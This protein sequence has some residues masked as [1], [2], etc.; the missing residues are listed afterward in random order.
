MK[1]VI[2]ISLREH[3]KALK[4]SSMAS[5]IETH[6]RQAK[7]SGIGYDEFLLDLA[8]TE[9]QVR[10]ENRLT[11][12]IRDAKFPLLKPVETFDLNAVP[13]LDMRLFRD[14]CGCNY[15]KEHRNVIFL[16]GSGTGKTH[17]ATALG[18]EA[19][20]AN[21]RTRFISGYGLVNELLE[22][23]ETRDLTRIMHRYSR[24]DLL[25]LDELGYIPFS[26]EGSELL[27]QVLAERYERGSVMITTNLGFADW[28]QV[29]GDPIIT[30]TLLDRLTHRAYTINCPWD[31]YRLKQSIKEKK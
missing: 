4:L 20:K 12:R 29:F 3:L 28:T 1:N 25:I 5:G 27:F 31:S 10:A 13:D 11:R 24:Y 14:L 30:A 8:T 26:K 23:R 7:E 2:L 18:I 19:C 21:Y 15:I 17:M 6:L 16:G 22:T 9:L